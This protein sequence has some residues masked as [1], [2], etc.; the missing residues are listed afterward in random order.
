[1]LL[2]SD[3][4]KDARIYNIPQVSE[5]VALIVGDVD[6]TSKRDI[7]VESQTG[8]L[9]RID[10]LHTSYLGLQYPLLF[11]YGKDGYRHD[12]LHRAS[13]ISQSSK[14]NRLTIRE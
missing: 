6:T 1:M 8:Q 14:R 12:I 9:Q 11:P 4:V 7:I 13:Q 10:E 2:I 3:R 5:V